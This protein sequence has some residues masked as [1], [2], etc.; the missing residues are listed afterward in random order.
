MRAEHSGSAAARLALSAL[1][2]SMAALAAT[3][4]LAAAEIQVFTS[5]AP[6]AVQK[7]LAPM[8]EKA[9][10]HTVVVTAETLNNIR[11]RLEAG[12]KPDVVVLPR[13]A[14]MPF[15]KSGALQ[16][17]SLVDV[18]RVGIGVVVREGATVPDVST[19][20]TLR[21]TLLNAKSIAHPDPK[22]GGFTGAYIDRMFERLGIADA[23][24]PKVTLGYAFTGGVENIAKG[25]AEL[26]LFNISEIVPIKGVTL[27]GPLPRELQNY[28]VFSGAL[29]SGIASPA[30]AGAY[31]RSLLE[32][33]AQAVWKA[34][35]ME[36]AN[37]SEN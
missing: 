34:G 15:V 19:V 30:P 13:A 35:G 9:T 5:G 11:K 22:G 21:K 32:P 17:D 1:T 8:F 27:V 7:R 4:P 12:A 14:L 36:G 3:A 16:A 31:L 10:G 2:I 26:G 24:R 28:L 25:V 33:A 37:G 6:S 23:V 29:H 18:A 20:D